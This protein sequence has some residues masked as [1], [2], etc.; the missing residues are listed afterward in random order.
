MSEE[1]PRSAL[2]AAAP[3]GLKPPSA[4]PER[5][6]VTAPMS[7]PTAG[8]AEKPLESKRLTEDT[9]ADAKTADTPNV[10]G[11]LL[12]TETSA[13]D[14][15]TAFAAIFR[16]WQTAY[17][18]LPG[19]TA[20]ERAA[21]AGLRCYRDRGN[22]TTLRHL[23]RPVI[24]ELV[25]RHQRR[26]H[27]AAIRMKDQSIT[28]EL[29]DREVTLNQT[30]IEPFWFGD[31]TLLWKPPALASPVI[32][33]GDRRPDV[34]WLRAQLDRAEGIQVANADQ[35]G[36]QARSP[37]PLFDEDLKKRVMAF[38]QANFVKADGIVGEQTLIQLNRATAGSA[39]PLLCTRAMNG[40]RHVVYP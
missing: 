12:L 29:G 16:Q 10:S 39:V 8:S 35:T 31:F 6:V 33:E 32:K 1:G 36:S 2:S 11:E 40:E 38:Q 20:C 14:M 28:V 15:D 37:S 13:T 19:M 24:L 21:K 4:K 30:E 5:E 23:N 18:L 7:G 26:H 25:D 9:I 27:V 22:W 34:L 17:P 3:T